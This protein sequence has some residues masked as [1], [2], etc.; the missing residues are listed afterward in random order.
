MVLAQTHA[1]DALAI[2]AVEVAAGTKVA[3]GS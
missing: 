1:V 2:I 3:G